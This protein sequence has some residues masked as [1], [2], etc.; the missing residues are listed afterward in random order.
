MKRRTHKK[1]RKR[2]TL[3]RLRYVGGNNGKCVFARMLG[4]LGNQLFVYAAGILVKNKVNLP[5]CL[6]KEGN[7]HSNIN[8]I[9][10]IFKQGS[11]YTNSDLQQRLDNSEIIF[12]NVYDAHNSF[13]NTN[14]KYSSNK[15]LYLNHTYYQNYESMKSV[16]PSIRNDFK[17]YFESKYNDLKNTFERESLSKCSAYMHIRRGDYNEYALPITYYQSALDLLHQN[18]SIKYLYILSNDIQ[19]CKDQNFN[20]YNI[21]IRWVDNPDELYSLYLMSLCMAGAILSGSTFSLWGVLLGADQ[22]SS[23]TIIYPSKWYMTHSDK[24]S[25]PTWWKKINL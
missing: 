13:K 5:L 14:I 23:S 6:I 2:R 1:Y 12:S 9:N 15:D 16:I 20:T 22:N 24:L 11:E 4:G 7:P 10:E 21:E 18:T 25:L 8:Y 3:K 17:I 19:W